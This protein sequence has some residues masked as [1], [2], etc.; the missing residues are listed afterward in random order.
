MRS[1]IVAVYYNQEIASSATW[2]SLLSHAVGAADCSVVAADNSTD[3]DILAANRDFCQ[4]SGILF[5]DMGGNRGLPSAYNRAIDS[6][7]R[8][9]A[10]EEENTWIILADQDTTFPEAFLEDV[11]D[12]ASHTDARLLGPHV[13]SGETILSPCRFDGT[14]FIPWEADGIGED[15]DT[16]EMY[17]IN[18]GLALRA[19]IFLPGSVRY[20]EGLFLDFADFDIEDQIRKLFPGGAGFLP[21]TVI[22]QGFSGA[23]AHTAEKDLTRYR[24][25]LLD[26]ENYYRKWGRWSSRTRAAL[27][28]RGVKLALKHHDARFLKKSG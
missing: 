18:S 8:Q 2:Q 28:G 27:F 6:I 5:I 24:Q 10:G 25:Y 11:T 17:F 12:A 22:Q 23:Q 21:H 9:C 3:R 15:A 7:L 4:E 14:R 20:D 26:G 16:R 19:D 13:K 1:F